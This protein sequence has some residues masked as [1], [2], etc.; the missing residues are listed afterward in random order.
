MNKQNDWRIIGEVCIDSA[1]L[2]L[3]DPIRGEAAEHW[4]MDRARKVGVGELDANQ[5][6]A[7]GIDTW[8]LTDDRDI[9]IGVALTTG[10]GDGVY[11]VEARYEDDETFGRRVAEVRI[12]FLPHPYFL[13]DEEEEIENEN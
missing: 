12:K 7:D 1:T 10:L 11:P 8:Q 5:E 3:C 2:V 6:A 4:W 13:S 9:S